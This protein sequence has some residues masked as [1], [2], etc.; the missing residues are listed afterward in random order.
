MLFQW[1]G[2]YVT[3]DWWTHLWL[4]EGYASWIE[5]LCID[6]LYPEWKIWTQFVATVKQTALKLDGKV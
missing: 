3:L 1:F 2:N 4:K 5:F 6:K